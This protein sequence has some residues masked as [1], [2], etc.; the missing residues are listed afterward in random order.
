MNSGP[1]S[2]P[3]PARVDELSWTSGWFSSTQD[4][5]LFSMLNRISAAE[6]SDRFPELR[7]N[8]RSRWNGGRNPKTPF[9]DGLGRSGGGPVAGME[10]AEGAGHG[11]GVSGDLGD[12]P[13]GD[14][15]QSSRDFLDGIHRLD[16]FLK[17]AHGRPGLPLWPALPV[18][19]TSN[20][21]APRTR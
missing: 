4:G 18:V 12:V 8:R 19:S 9:E 2:I 17:G 15:E 13:A 11:V 5:S 1:D 14:G 21:T 3:V 20:Q 10:H 7:L 16:G 6:R